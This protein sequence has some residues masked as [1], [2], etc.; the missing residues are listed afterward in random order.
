MNRGV[1]V[2]VP[3]SVWR[4]HRWRE[5]RATAAAV[6]RATARVH[7]HVRGCRLV[8]SPHTT[9]ALAQ[10]RLMATPVARAVSE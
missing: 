6:E 7:S 8:V 1:F 3:T 10:A 5:P 9:H 4:Q 2:Q